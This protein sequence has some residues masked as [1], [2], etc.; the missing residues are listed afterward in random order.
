MISF[1]EVIESLKCHFAQFGTINSRYSSHV[2]RDLVSPLICSKLIERSL[3]AI[4]DLLLGAKPI[5]LY[6]IWSVGRWFL[7]KFQ[8]F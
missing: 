1:H 8:L 6:F 4:T 5:T 3:F 2:N 7:Q